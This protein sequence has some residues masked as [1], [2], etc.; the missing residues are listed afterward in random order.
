VVRPVRLDPPLRHV[1][2]GIAEGEAVGPDGAIL[3][4]LGGTEPDLVPRV[5]LDQLAARLV[6]D[7]PAPDEF[8]VLLHE[9]RQERVAEPGALFVSELCPSCELEDLWA[10]LVEDLLRDDRVLAA[11]ARDLVGLGHRLEGRL[12]E[13]D[14]LGLGLVRQSGALSPLLRLSILDPGLGNPLER[15]LDLTDLAI[16]QCQ[17]ALAVVEGLAVRRDPVEEQRDRLAGAE[18]V[19]GVARHRAE[20]VVG[21]DRRA[22]VMPDQDLALGRARQ[23]AEANLPA[24]RDTTGPGNH[25]V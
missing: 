22:E 17:P 15:L 19:R 7:A 11:A 2:F 4:D 1:E 12:L 3:G 5:R 25:T 24:P 21:A 23:V 10:R 6:E 20:H 9:Q 8:R 16:A 18:R 13:G 14:A